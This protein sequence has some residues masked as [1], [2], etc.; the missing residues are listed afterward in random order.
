MLHTVCALRARSEGGPPWLH[1][2][3]AWSIAH[4][5]AG[6]ETRSAFAGGWYQAMAETAW[7][8]ARLG[9][10]IDWTERGLERLPASA[11]LPL[12]SGA[13]A[14]VRAL[15][16]AGADPRP[17]GDRFSDVNAR[18]LRGELLLR[19]RVRE[20]LER[21]RDALQSAIR[22]DSSVAEPHL[23]L[24]RV[25]WKLGDRERAR[26]SLAEA[27][28]RRPDAGTAF[29]AHLFLGGLAEEAGQ[30]EE[31]ASEY[32]AAL[33]LEPRAQSARLAL[34]HARL[35]RGDAFGARLAVEKSLRSAG[36][37]VTDPYWGYP[38]GLAFGAEG[39]LERLRRESSR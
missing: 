2:S 27:L 34:S 13:L 33:G 14:E 1:E 38:W 10:A 31:A 15:Q 24:G 11:G 37:R 9:D 23:R 17:E 20:H 32:E 22:A 28:A 16:A 8:E 18:R 3:I 7:G 30:L 25:S 39:R 21:A 5:R 36:E 4:A 12:V 19:R 6:V 29:L 35:R 26:A